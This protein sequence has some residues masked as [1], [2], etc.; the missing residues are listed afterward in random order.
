MSR[1]NSNV[2]SMIAQRVNSMNN[3]MLSGTLEK[4]STGFRINRGSDD[5]A[6]L[7]I[8]E[9]LRGEIKGINAAIGNAQRAEQVMNIAEGGLQEISNMLVEVQSLVGQ[10]ANE[11]GVSAEEREANQL[12]ID[13]ILSTIDRIANSTSFQGT[14]LLNGNY[15]YT[16]SGN[17]SAA[18]GFSDVTVNSVKLSDTA[19]ASRAVTVTVTQ[20]AQTARVALALSAG[21]LDNGGSGSVT[22]EVAGARGAQQFSFAS[23]TANSAIVGA[24]N[25]FTEAIG[26]S[27]S[28]SGSDVRINS[29]GFGSESFVRVREIANAN[30]STNF[31]TTGAPG[32]ATQESRAVG[33]DAQVN[34]NGVVATARGL[35][36]RVALDGFDVSVSLLGDNAINVA[37]ASETFYV[38]G[39]GADF[40]LAPDVNLAGKVSLGIETVTTSNLGNAVSGFL[41]EL[42]SGGSANVQNGNLT[43]AQEVLDLATKQVSSLRGRLGAFTKNVVGSTINS[44]GVA[45]E[46]TTAAESA[47]RDTDF[48]AETASMTRNQI[49]VQASTQALA[50]SNS[51]PQSVLQLMRG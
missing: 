43:K 24:I 22:F 23:G 20:S 18:D 38:T 1:I 7:I 46:N 6:G 34:I 21:V 32:A 42:K 29:T 8:S 17:Y 2:P 30:P 28:L 36:A 39:G 25:A 4:L 19:G 14:K 16:L 11:A 26:V 49:L 51:A 47:I 31:V 27:A 50:L 35:T 45:L 41:S 33:R 15:D 48:A 9:N 12:Q 10:T 5:P 13:N 44:L 3:R 37:G 40:N